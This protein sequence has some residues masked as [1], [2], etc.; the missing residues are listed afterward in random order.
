[1]REKTLTRDTNDLPLHRHGKVELLTL[2]LVFV[3]L[4]VWSWEYLG[5]S[6]D[7]ASTAAS[8]PGSFFQ[9]T[10]PPDFS[11]WQSV[12]E[13]LLETLVMA[14]AGTALGTSMG[15]GLATLA[16]R[17]SGFI[18]LRQISRFLIVFFR[19]IPDLVLAMILVA[20]VGLGPG[21]GALALA[22]GSIGMIGRLMTQAI[23]DV[24]GDIVRTA[25]S[26]GASRL[27]VFVSG[28]MPQIIAPLVAATLYRLD[29]NLR[30]GTVLGLV[31]AG[32]IG[33]LLRSS[34]GSLDY[35]S[36]F[37]III[38]IFVMVVV[39]ETISIR[40]RAALF[41][42]KADLGAGLNDR[43]FT[44]WAGL[45]GGILL[46]LLVIVGFGHIFQSIA[47]T[48][49]RI[50]EFAETVSAFLSPDFVS[51]WD[52]ILVGTIETMAL[53]IVATFLGLFIG[54]PVGIAAARNSSKSWVAFLLGRGFL[55]AKRGL[56][57]LVIAL[58]FVAWLGLG[59][60]TGV[61]A[62]AIGTGGI[63]AKFVADTIE[64]ADASKVRSLES[65][66]ANRLQLFMA[67]ILPQVSPAIL[68]H[69]MYS[70]DLNVR[71]STIVGIVGGGGLGTI[72]VS[73]VRLMDY[74]TTSAIVLVIFAVLV[75]IEL[76]TTRVRSLIG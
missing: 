38:L 40:V 70:L 74:G 1:M 47:K 65:V 51:Q 3:V 9:R 18:V 46:A 26:T 76:L 45:V 13:L 57:T 17:T 55:L 30:S 8:N 69:I 50:P 67:G 61:L 12:L 6:S 53:A 71:Y 14:A 48:L 72:I 22:L 41:S 28:V 75:A 2:V 15:L 32:G 27:S 23:E 29:I 16:A 54:L 34:L 43:S 60:L 20:M 68:G 49:G 7:L 52:G 36:V 59:P 37:A 44:W 25:K 4:V 33:L 42:P 35:Q 39:I 31:G 19:S 73:S 64:E 11:N 62:L 66:G 5:L 56:P 21:A 24:G 10:W 63:L 58:I